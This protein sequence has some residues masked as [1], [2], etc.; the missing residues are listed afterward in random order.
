MILSVMTPADVVSEW[1]E[2]CSVCE[3]F[4]LFVYKRLTK[5][6]VEFKVNRR[7]SVMIIAI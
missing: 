1:H 3:Q 6:T 2:I 4:P 5:T 7:L